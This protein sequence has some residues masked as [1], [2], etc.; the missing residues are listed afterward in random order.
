MANT[1]APEQA[2][3]RLDPGDRNFITSLARGLKILEAFADQDVGELSLGAIAGYVELGK[4][5]TWRLAHTL[6]RLGYLRQNRESRKFSLS[7]RI[8]SLGYAYFDSMDLMKAARPFLRDLADECEETVNMAVRDGDYL[9]YVERLKTSQVVNINLHVGSRLELYNTSMGRALI[10]DLPPAWL[11]DYVKRLQAQGKA[12]DY[13]ESAGRKLLRILQ[14]TRKKGYA[15]NN[16]ELV[17]GLISV[18]GPVRDATDQVVAAV[19]IAAPTARMSLAKMEQIHVPHLLETTR[20][21]S[22]ALGNFAA[23]RRVEHP[24]DT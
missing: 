7:P 4:T 15:V 17:M 16:E 3:K 6:V 21:I 2:D 5:T 19:N 8:L 1:T 11:T 12:A 18:A 10:A 13:T 9:V 20:L 24:K 23:A 14:Q 22:S